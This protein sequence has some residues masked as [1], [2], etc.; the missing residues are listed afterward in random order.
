MY[1]CLEKNLLFLSKL[2]L[3]EIYFSS[4]NAYDEGQRCYYEIRAH[5]FFSLEK[6]PLLKQF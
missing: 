3:I 1:I 2:I 5:P 6:F 4:L